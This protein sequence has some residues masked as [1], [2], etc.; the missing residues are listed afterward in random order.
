M[1]NSREDR[2]GAQRQTLCDISTE[3]ASGER[4][5]RKEVGRGARDQDENQ[6]EGV[7]SGAKGFQKK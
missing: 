5:P 1:K 6:E 3:E 7:A 4:K 2:A